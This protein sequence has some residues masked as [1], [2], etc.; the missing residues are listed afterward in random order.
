MLSIKRDFPLG[1]QRASYVRGSQHLLPCDS[2]ED[3]E[4]CM[5]T[6]FTL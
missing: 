2:L 4:T 5:D 3:P 6:G 1:P